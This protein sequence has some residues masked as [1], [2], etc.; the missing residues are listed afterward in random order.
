MTLSC[1]LCVRQRRQAP[2]STQSA[3]QRRLRRHPCAQVWRWSRQYAAQLDGEPLPAMQ[4]LSQWLERNIP[5]SDND[6]SVTRISHGDYKCSPA[7]L[8]MTMR[9]VPGACRAAFG[10]SVL[11]LAAC[12]G[13][14]RRWHGC[15]GSVTGG[16]LVQPSD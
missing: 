12:T 14:C 3:W 6:A 2:A 15:K 4:T 10:P 5:L 9:R 7:A 13:L 8:C 11:F 16:T 1:V